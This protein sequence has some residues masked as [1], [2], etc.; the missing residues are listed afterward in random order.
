MT[1]AVNLPG[2]F[3]RL[4]TPKPVPCQQ[5]KPSEQNAGAGM[6]YALGLKM[7]EDIAAAKT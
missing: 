1:Q 2:E 3:G 6:L 4:L 5:R 7:R